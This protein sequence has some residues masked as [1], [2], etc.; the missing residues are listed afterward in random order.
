MIFISILIYLENK[1]CDLN[2]LE[3]ETSFVVQH[4]FN[5]VSR[6]YLVIGYND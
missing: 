1:L 4:M 6:K 3:C 2:P 5:F